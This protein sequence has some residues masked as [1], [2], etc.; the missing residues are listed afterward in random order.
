MGII[1]QHINTVKIKKMTKKEVTKSAKQSILEGKT[2]QETFESLKT[3]SKLSAEELAKIIQPIPSLQARQKY[4]TLQMI[5]IGL[6]LLT[7]LIKMTAGIPIVIQNGIRWLPVLFVF[8]IINILLLIGVANY[9]QSSHKFVAIF[10]LLSLVRSTNE[11]L[12]QPLDIFMII[13]LIL[14][15]GLIGLGFYLNAKLCPDY[16]IKKE[17]YQNNQGQDRLRNVI[18]FND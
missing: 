5:L 7:I 9:M 6:L 15:A 2:K 8:P 17:R 16:S 11:F 1:S 14:I 4:K 3:S 13:D 18:Q 12:G 10:T